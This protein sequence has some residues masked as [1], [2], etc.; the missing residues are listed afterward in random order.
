MWHIARR[1]KR[2]V[3]EPFHFNQEA[4]RTSTPNT[5]V[6]ASNG[7]LTAIQVGSLTVQ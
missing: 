5:N 1:T 2:P 6:N 3:R 4:D 7:R